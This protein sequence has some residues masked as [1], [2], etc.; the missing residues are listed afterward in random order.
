M[1]SLL[2][3]PGVLVGHD[4]RIGDGWL[5]G[6]T[7]VVLPPGS[8]GGVDVRGGGPGTAETDA[9][10]PSTLVQTVDAVALCGGSAYGLSAATG[11]QLW[12]ES[13]GQGYAVPGGVVPIVPAAVIFDL[14]RGGDFTA[15]PDV[16]MGFAAAAAAGPGGTHDGGLRGCVGAG[17]GAVL[18]R[19]MYKGGIGMASVRIP[20]GPVPVPPGMPEVELP[21]GLV[22]GALAVVNA[23]GMP[24]VGP[25]TPALATQAG[26]D[27]AERSAAEEVPEAAG[28]ATAA[29]GPG[30]GSGAGP[31][32][33][34]GGAGA[35]R[36]GA[37]GPGGAAG[38]AA[39]ASAPG[40]VAGGA[41]TTLVV[42]ATNAALSPAE[43]RR[44][45]TAAHAGLARALDPSHTLVDGDTVFAVS[46]GGLDLD[47][48][49]DAARVA[50]LMAVQIAA[51]D[52]T[53]LAIL[54]GVRSATAV[55]TPAGTWLPFPLP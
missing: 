43:C 52:A 10:D 27:A 51:A 38:P 9:L 3:V 34:A 8:T 35:A 7:A 17:A 6:V 47:R 12:L 41:N 20:A 49:S 14:G 31:A 36:A 2:D 25:G 26:Q 32:A 5:T 29:P 44:L 54:D 21:E 1:G 55:T 50:G 22:V 40:A 15:R 37:S 46:T 23:A 39:G 30:G 28:A 16:A 45:A 11:V 53:R 13:Q 19:G 42:V 33:G 4:H 48:T 24:V 18:G